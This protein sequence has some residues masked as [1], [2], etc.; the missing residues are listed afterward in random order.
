MRYRGGLLGGVWAN[1]F[2]SD[3]GNGKFDGVNLVANFEDLNPAN[4]LWTKQ[5]HLYSQIDT[6]EDRYLAFEK[7]WGGFYL[8]T[9]QKIHYIVEN[10][11]VGNRL[12]KGDLELRSGRRV[13]LK[14]IHHPIV[15]FASKGDNITPP[16]Q[17]L[18][19]IPQ[20]YESDAEIMELGHVIIYIIHESIGHLGI[21]V[22]GSIAKKEHTEI[23]GNFDL[24]EYLAP[25]L[26]EMTINEKAG[27]L[28]QTDF[29][30]HFERKT[31]KE[32]IAQIGGIEIDRAG[33]EAGD[34][35]RVSDLSEINDRMYQALVQPWIRLWSNDFTAEMYRRL[36]PMRA[37]RYM[38]S[39]LNL[40]LL[41][42]NFLAPF[43]KAHRL[44]TGPDNPYIQI[45]RIISGGIEEM[46]DIYRDTRDRFDKI[47]FRGIYGSVFMQSIL[48]RDINKE[49][50]K[51]AEEKRLHVKRKRLAPEDFATG[52]FPEAIIRIINL[53]CGIDRDYD[54]KEFAAAENIVWA[55]EELR[56]VP[57]ATLK[58]IIRREAHLVY[59]DREQAIKALP[60]MAPEPASRRRL[61]DAAVKIAQASGRLT[62]SEKNV[63]N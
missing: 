7:W 17:A 61:C 3:L 47:A 54:R 10:L 45:E 30:P 59:A 55:N 38:K 29:E 18:N 52:G 1:S 13:N 32:M 39:D 14:N 11:F 19:W 24:I 49:A 20:V 42:L 36:H 46:L 28:G 26:Y 56:R 33:E 21:F 4:T 51:A 40:A 57:P 9:A 50:A 22:S 6:E 2:L 25:G 8:M 5:Y 62:K 34:F 23:I 63:L 53:V 27:R 41:P 43:V 37:G 12:E 16:Q 48:P 31:I 58:Q 35:R 15:V 60:R 44:S